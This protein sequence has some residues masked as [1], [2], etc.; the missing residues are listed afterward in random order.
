MMIDCSCE[1]KRGKPPIF[2]SL[3][4]NSHLWRFINSRIIERMNLKTKKK[5]WKPIWWSCFESSQAQFCKHRQHR[6]QNSKSRACKMNCVSRFKRAVVIPLPGFFKDF[7]S[8]I[9]LA[10]K[11]QPRAEQTPQGLTKKWNVTDSAFQLTSVLCFFY[12]YYL[13]TY[14]PKEN[15]LTALSH[16]T[17]SEHV[18]CLEIRS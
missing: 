8:A 10:C 1:S 9:L 14:D 7:C 3:I 6:G 11:L 13:K 15:S 12:Y 2:P 4:H 16:S 17:S 18:L 5:E